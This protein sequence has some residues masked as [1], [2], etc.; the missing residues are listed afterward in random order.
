[1]GRTLK[2]EWGQVFHFDFSEL[3]LKAWQDRF[4]SSIL[5]RTQMVRAA[6]DWPWSN[7][8]VMI[9]ET[10]TPEWLD[11]RT[12]LTTPGEA[13]SETVERY[14]QFVAEGKDQP[15]LWEQMKNQVFL[16]SD[17]FVESVRRQIPRNRD[18]R[19]VPQAKRRPPAK[20]LTEYARENRQ[21]N[22]AIVAAYRS[23]GHTPQDYR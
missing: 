13:E 5:V 6:N 7:Y 20:T 9:G 18:L 21:R 19:E 2:E 4:V 17:A 22:K 14:I 8:R 16:C 15:S 10:Q 12:I 1:M 3:N 23:G 11:T